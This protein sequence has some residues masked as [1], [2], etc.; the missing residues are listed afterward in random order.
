MVMLDKCI[1]QL[2]TNTGNS[3]SAAC[4]NSMRMMLEAARARGFA[5]TPDAVTTSSQIAIR[6]ICAR[7]VEVDGG[8]AVTLTE[9]ERQ[10]IY[11]LRTHVDRLLSSITLNQFEI[12]AFDLEAKAHAEDMGIVREINNYKKPKPPR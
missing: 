3:N 12:I 7:A 6:T 10:T 9:P 5:D 8:F 4:M 11:S 2:E 1:V